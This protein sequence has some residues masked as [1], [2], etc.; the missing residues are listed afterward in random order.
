MPLWKIDLKAHFLSFDSLTADQ[1]RKKNMKKLFAFLL[2]LIL[3]FSMAA[4]GKKEDQSKET[5]LTVFAAAS[6]T[7]SL[8]VI[9]DKYMAAHP[10][11]KILFNFDS[12]GKLLTQINEGAVCDVFISA[13]PKQMNSLDEAGMLL[14]GTSFDL[15]EN[16]VALA[17]A[18]GNPKNIQSFDELAEL[19]KNGDVSLAIGNSDV[20]VGQYTE[21]IFKY[22]GI[23][24]SSIS[25]KLTY[26]SNVKEVTSAVSE[27]AVDCGIIYASDAY[28]ADLEVSAVATA[29]M[30]GQVIYPAAVIKASENIDAAKAFLEYL[31][32]AEASAEFEA[33]LFTPLVK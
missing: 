13:A 12:S 3:A 19:L 9:G 25:S 32:G 20:P 31:T 17:V 5:E 1:E 15:L 26:G 24:E 2:V 18:E 10:D 22:Y 27:S 4:C 33:V 8:T 11:V 21:K 16:K 30:C 28:S 7:E 6:L 29:E 14:E 23:D